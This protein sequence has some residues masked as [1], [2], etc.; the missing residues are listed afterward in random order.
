[1]KA[2]AKTKT[3]ASSKYERA[4]QK[5]ADEYAEVHNELGDLEIFALPDPQ[6]KTV[7]IIEVSDSFPKMMKGEGMWPIHF[8]AIGSFRF[9]TAQL[10]ATRSEW[11]KIKNG[12]LKIHAAWDVKAL[13]KVWPRE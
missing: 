6:K 10:I 12:K 1:M 7:Q 11:K 8:K 4:V 2:K 3:S 9:P 5:L 13:K